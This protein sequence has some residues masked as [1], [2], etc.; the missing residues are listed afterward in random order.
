MKYKFVFLGSLCAVICGILFYVNQAANSQPYNIQVSF[1]DVG[2]GDSAL[3]QNSEGYNILIDGGQISEGQTVLAYLRNNGVYSLSAVIASH[4]DSDHIGGLISVLEATDIS[5]DAVI[6]NGYPGDTQTWNEFALAVADEGLTLVPAQ[7]PGELTW[8]MTTAYILNPLP[9]M[10][11][12]DT[13][14]VSL[15]LLFDQLEIEY[16]FPGDI[17]S[18]VESEIIARGTPV[19]ADILKV[20]HHGSNTSTSIE[21]LNAVQPFDSVISVGP[22]PYGH[23]GVETLGRLLTIGSNIWRTDIH[24]TILITSD[25]G[26]TYQVI[27]T[28]TGVY[29]YLP[30]V[31]R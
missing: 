22:N 10:V 25:D 26:Y 21:F 8:G 11:N 17:D 2:E 28:S 9:G 13:N 20:A 23:P 7:F 15:V 31:I 1:I 16:L 30:M 12:P 4:A 19:A 6:Y 27:P 29:I 3:I 24:G 5:V 18:T 14:E